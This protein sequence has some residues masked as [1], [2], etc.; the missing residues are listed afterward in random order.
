MHIVVLNDLNSDYNQLES[1]PA[2]NKKLQTSKNIHFWLAE[3]CAVLQDRGKGTNNNKIMVANVNVTC[4][5]LQDDITIQL[6]I[7]DFT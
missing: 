4:S 1:L 6:N 7:A 2:S 5:Y 3:K